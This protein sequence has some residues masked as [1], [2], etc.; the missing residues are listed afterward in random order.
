[1]PLRF[2]DHNGRMA[3]KPTTV[4]QYLATLA[5]EVRAV[6]EQIR[7]T[8]HDVIEDGE[9]AISYAIPAIKVDGKVVVF[10]SG[11]STHVSL[12]PVPPGSAAFEKR[13]APYVAGKGTL[14]FPLSKPVPY[15]LIAEIGRAHLK[16]HQAAMAQKQ[17]AAAPKKVKKV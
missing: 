9:D 10:Y 12:Y 11:W 1:M 8:L 13:I 16:R 6:V 15:E 17:R 2:R 5:A 7:A 14:K 3:D 4:E